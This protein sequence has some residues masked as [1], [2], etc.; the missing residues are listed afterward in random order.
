LP[1]IGVGS[2]LKRGELPLQAHALVAV[3][4]I[5]ALAVNVVSTQPF[6]DGITLRLVTV[7]LLAALLYV[8]ARWV[9][10]WDSERGPISAGYTW[11][12]SALVAVLGCQELRGARP[13]WVAVAWAAVGFSRLLVGVA[14][15]R[16]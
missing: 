10:R 14:A 6:A 4:F 8:C 11:M 5:R 1:L 16:R 7:S 9:K 13:G 2:N 3:A 12:G 15:G